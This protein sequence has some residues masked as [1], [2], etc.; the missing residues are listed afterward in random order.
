MDNNFNN[1]ISPML[2][3]PMF[4][5]FSTASSK[6]AMTY[7]D[8]FGEATTVTKGAPPR[9]EMDISKFAAPKVVTCLMQLTQKGKPQLHAG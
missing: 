1:N 3:V 9:K 7:N 2:S 8:G 6:H 4:K 5:Y